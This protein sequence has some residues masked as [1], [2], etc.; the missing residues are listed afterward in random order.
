M[1]NSQA[2]DGR[3]GLAFIGGD[4]EAVTSVA[5]GDFIVVTAKAASSSDFEDYELNRPFFAMKAVASLASGDEVYKIPLYFLGQATGKNLSHSKN[6]TDVTMDYDEATNN[7]TDGIV[8][9]SGSISGMFITERIVDDADTGVNILKSRFKTLVQID[10]SGNVKTKDAATTEKDLFVFC[11]N[12]RNA[13]AGD[14]L[15]IDVVPALITGLSIGG[16]YGSSQSFDIDFSG[17]ASDENNFTGSELQLE[18]TEAL[19]A[20]FKTARPAV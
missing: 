12:L 14:L 5:V 13:K 19:L 10:K 4:P 3:L 6:T 8:S 20:V 1:A 17:N 15:D 2:R 7:V 16:E 18:A 9:T 11:W